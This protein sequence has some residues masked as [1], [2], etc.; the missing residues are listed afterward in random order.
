MSSR[1]AAATF[2]LGITILSFNLQHYRME[3][4]G[5]RLWKNGKEKKNECVKETLFEVLR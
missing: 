5:N 1:N 3:Y 2:F 4:I